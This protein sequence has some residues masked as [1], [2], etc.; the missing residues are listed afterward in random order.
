MATSLQWQQGFAFRDG[1]SFRFADYHVL[2]RPYV[3]DSQ[4]ER[5]PLGE[6][7]SGSLSQPL[8]SQIQKL[9]GRH[10][11]CTP[12]S[13]Q[14]FIR[15]DNVDPLSLGVL[16]QSWELNAV[17]RV[18]GGSYGLFAGAQVG[19]DRVLD[20]D[21]V[22]ITSNGFVDHPRARSCRPSAGRC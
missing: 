1:W 4:L 9:A 10:P 2:G 17:Y 8:Y 6:V 15:G 19:G 13:H 18:G 5:S 20:S 11:S 21:G 16:R 3:F 22:V 12:T 7:V 14:T